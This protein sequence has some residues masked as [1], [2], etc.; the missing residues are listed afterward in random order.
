[1]TTVNV[2]REVEAARNLY[3]GIGT[4][5]GFIIGAIIV[6]AIIRRRPHF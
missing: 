2:K 1:V 4:P 5:I 6:Y 3:L